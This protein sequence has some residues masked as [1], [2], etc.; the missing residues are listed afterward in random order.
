MNRT[1]HYDQG[2]FSTWD[3]IKAFCPKSFSSYEGYLWGNIVKYLLRCGFKHLEPDGDLEKAQN[4][5]LRLLEHRRQEQCQKKSNDPV[6]AAAVEAGTTT[7]KESGSASTVTEEEALR[8]QELEI[9]RRGI[10]AYRSGKLM[11]QR[12]PE[13][14]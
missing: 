7:E 5:L 13:E 1:N 14:N 8:E 12:L 11:V 6:P 3:I 9:Y 2:G 4:Y 10:Q